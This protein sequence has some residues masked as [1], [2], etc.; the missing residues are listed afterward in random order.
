MVHA[1][2]EPASSSVQA[3]LSPL[4]A[5]AI[6]TP[7]SKLVSGDVSNIHFLERFLSLSDR[8]VSWRVRLSAGLTI[9]LWSFA[10]RDL[11]LT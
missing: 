3:S 4:A 8:L 7:L 11:A 6:L 9:S 10:R 1:I 2:G 5:T